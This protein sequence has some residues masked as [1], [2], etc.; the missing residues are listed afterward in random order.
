MTMNSL[1]FPAFFWRWRLR[2]IAEFT[3]EIHRNPIEND[4]HFIATGCNRIARLRKEIARLRNRIARSRKQIATHRHPIAPMRNDN[5]NAM[6]THPNQ[7]QKSWRAEPR[8]RPGVG[9]ST[10][11][12]GPPRD[13]TSAKVP[14]RGDAQQRRMA[15]SQSELSS[16][17]PNRV[18]SLAFWRAAVR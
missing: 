13:G 11:S 6:S 9:I 5:A 10:P 3:D 2:N 16:C 8:K 12:R 4:R 17:S 18:P 14:L 7:G 15:K 1:A